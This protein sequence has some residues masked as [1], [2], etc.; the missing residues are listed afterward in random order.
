MGNNDE[1][2]SLQI[3]NVLIYLSVYTSKYGMQLISIK[4]ILL[5]IAESTTETT[6]GTTTGTTPFC[7]PYVTC[8]PYCGRKTGSDG[9]MA[10]DCQPETACEVRNTDKI[11]T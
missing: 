10:C 8:G 3:F 9:C 7:P 2:Y 5:L 11:V 6:T 1:L 4:N